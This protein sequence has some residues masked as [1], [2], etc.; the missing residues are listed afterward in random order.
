MV[1]GYAKLRDGNV[2]R[3]V[4]VGDDFMIDLDA[5]GRPLGVETIGDA[6]WTQALVRLAMAGNI[7][8]TSGI[9]PGYTPTW[10]DA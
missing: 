5:D 1:V 3:T 10:R 7:R 2:A 4:E 6:D 8:V 9:K